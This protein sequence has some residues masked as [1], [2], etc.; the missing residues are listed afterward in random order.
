MYLIINSLFSLT[1]ILLIGI[2]TNNTIL[3]ESCLERPYIFI[4]AYSLGETNKFCKELNDLIIYSE[5]SYSLL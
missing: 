4:S 3:T 1:F 5:K 2:I